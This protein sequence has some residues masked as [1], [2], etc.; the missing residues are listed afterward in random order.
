MVRAVQGWRWM[1]GQPTVQQSFIVR[2]PAAE[3]EAEL[4][5]Q[6][7]ATAALP[8]WLPTPNI[9]EVPADEAPVPSL[10]DIIYQHTPSGAEGN[11]WC[12]CGRG[13][14]S[15]REH[16]EHVAL[17]VTDADLMVLPPPHSDDVVERVRSAL[18]ELERAKAWDWEY[19]EGENSA[20]AAANALAAVVPELL[21]EV[22]RLRSARRAW[23]VLDE[24]GSTM[25][26][27]LDD[28]E[29]AAS[30][31]RTTE[32]EIWRAEDYPPF[33]RSADGR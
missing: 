2:V 14:G 15:F 23:A 9:V 18:A 13:F 30:K 32:V 7:A 33:K 3:L 20:N 21:A 26:V 31:W 25:G 8:G 4:A 19:G 16:A 17:M 24:D 27:I 1:P 29:Y 28:E 22:E 5:R 10:A 12:W 6:R 11:V